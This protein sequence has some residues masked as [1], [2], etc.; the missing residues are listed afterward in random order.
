MK[1]PE[2]KNFHGKLSPWMNLRLLTIL[3]TLTE[4]ATCTLPYIEELQSFEE[5]RL[6]TDNLVHICQFL[7][8]QTIMSLRC[9]CRSLYESSML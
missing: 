5:L 1:R 4:L 9:T 8:M 6:S 3:L 7:D 2:I